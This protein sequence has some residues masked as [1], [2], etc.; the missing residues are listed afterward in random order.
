M[1]AGQSVQ[2][3]YLVGLGV[4]VIMLTIGHLVRYIMH[5]ISPRSWIFFPMV[6][7]VVLLAG[8]PQLI[9]YAP[10]SSFTTSLEQLA[11]WLD[12]RWW[13]SLIL[14]VWF[15]WISLKG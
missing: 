2:S 14:I 6:L 12:D 7:I 5:D 8:M 4:F 1:L 11:D 13:L 15:S 3:W 9:A 10:L